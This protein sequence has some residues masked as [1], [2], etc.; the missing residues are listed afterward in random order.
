APEIDLGGAIHVGGAVRAA[1]RLRW[2]G[3]LEVGGEVAASRV[4]FDGRATIE[5]AVV[6]T[7]VVGRLRDD[8]RIGSIRADRVTITR[9]TR[10]RGGGRLNVLTIEAKE[11]DLEAVHAQ[12]VR[13]ERIALGP[14]CQ[15]AEV[16]GT[17]TR[18][19]PSAHV[20]PASQS[21][22]PHGLTR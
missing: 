5:G 16:E 20:G 22:P 7:E 3:D 4:E 8:S 1:T 19:H 15:I 12:H 13:A 2:K 17:I 9:P 6:A 11:V 18:R 14:G 21:A 10:L